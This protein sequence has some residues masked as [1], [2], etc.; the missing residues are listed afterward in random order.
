MARLAGFLFG[1]GSLSLKTKQLFFSGKEEDMKEIKRDLNRLGFHTLGNI[2]RNT[3][4]NGEC[5]SFGE[6][7]RSLL[8]LFYS[9]E[10]PV[11]KKTDTPYGIPSWILGGGQDIQQE[12]LAAFFGAEGTKPKFQGRTVKPIVISQTKR[13]D[14]KDNL[15]KFLGQLQGMLAGFG[16]QTEMRIIQKIKT[17]RKDGTTSIEGKIWVKNSTNNILRFLEQIGYKYCNYKVSEAIKARQYLLW[18]KTLGKKIYSFR[19]VPHY[20]T[21]CPEQVLG[22][23]AYF[24]VCGL[25]KVA[26]PEY[27]YCLSTENKKFIANDIVVHNCDALTREAQQA[28]R[29][30][31]ENY[32][33][34][35][36]FVLSAN[37]SSKIIDPIQS[38]CA[39][40]RF[41][42]LSREEIFEI[43]ERITVGEHLK[44]DE[45]AKEALYRVCGG[46][47]RRLENLL[48]SAASLEKHITEKVIYELASFAEPKEIKEVLELALKQRFSDAR[49]KLLE[50]M[51]SYGLAGIDVIKQVQQEIISL[52]ITER[53]KMMLIEK[54]GEAEFRMT[55]G[56][57]EYVQLE[58]FLAQVA[59]VGSLKE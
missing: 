44:V 21:W 40:F 10:V 7:K 24:Y 9:L 17:I 31:M 19:P 22:E 30:T 20:N 11:G 59:L 2:R 16:I 5:W 13:I 46:D 56:S 53:Q 37:Y 48:Q 45:K 43:I 29:R 18:R 58:A 47:C 1:D 49:A 3:W 28:L 12:F 32:T 39:I 52:G 35:C 54:C 14:L 34:T 4:R 25:E 50:T 33:Q 38:R 57:D 42:P 55:E 36:R 51:L 26:D 6:Y 23:S 27:V 8:S 41:K 15:H